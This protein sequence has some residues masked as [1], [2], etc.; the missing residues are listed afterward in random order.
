MPR[1]LVPVWIVRRGH[2]AARRFLSRDEAEHTA[3]KLGRSSVVDEVAATA[4]ELYRWGLGPLP[5]GYQPRVTTALKPR[6]R[7]ARCPH[8]NRALYGRGRPRRGEVRDQP[9]PLTIEDY[10]G[11]NPATLAPAPR[12]SDLVN[13]PDLAGLFDPRLHDEL[14][15]DY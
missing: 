11:P 9:A 8:C 2:E 13:R 1:P 15:E 4:R 5:P 3:H 6:K 14:P 10:D 7:P 12:P